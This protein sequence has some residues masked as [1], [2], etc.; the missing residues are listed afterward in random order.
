MLESSSLSQ[1]GALSNPYC[2]NPLDPATGEPLQPSLDP[3]QKARA[4]DGSLPGYD[5]LAGSYTVPYVMQFIDT[6]VVNRSNALQVW[7]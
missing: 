4:S 7:H 6:R 1:L 3:H 5:P 2:L